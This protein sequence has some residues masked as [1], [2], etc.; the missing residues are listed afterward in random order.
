[1]ILFDL[2]WSWGECFCLQTLSPCGACNRDEV[3]M[4]SFD[5]ILFVCGKKGLDPPAEKRSNPHRA[6]MLFTIHTIQVCF[7]SRVQNYNTFVSSSSAVSKPGRCSLVITHISVCQASQH[8]DQ[9]STI[10]NLSHQLSICHHLHTTVQIHQ[11]LIP[12]RNHY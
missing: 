3:Y 4:T 8:N 7:T 6:Q 2:C 9:L 12:R 10:T 5:V 11:H 1:M